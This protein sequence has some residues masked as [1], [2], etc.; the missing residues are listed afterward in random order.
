MG[1]ADVF[2]AEDRVT[3]K[4]S[5]LQTL[6]RGCV[7]YELLMNGIK[8]RTSHEAMYQMMTGKYLEE[9]DYD[10]DDAQ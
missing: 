10:C 7:Q 2:N 5:D 3:L 8:T 1:L 4:V 6:V 9:E